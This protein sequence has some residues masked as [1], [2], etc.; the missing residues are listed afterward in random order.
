MSQE[1]EQP[2]VLFDLDDSAAPTTQNHINPYI[3]KLAPG[4]FTDDQRNRP[5]V[6]QQENPELYE[7]RQRFFADHEALV[8]VELYPTSIPALEILKPVCSQQGL[9]SRLSVCAP[10][11]LAW[12]ERVGLDQYLTQI[13]TRE[14]PRQRHEFYKLDKAKTLGAVVC[15]DDDPDVCDFYRAGDIFAVVIAQDWNSEIRNGKFIRRYPNMLVAA[16]EIA[17]F[18][19]IFDFIEYYNKD[20]Q[21]GSYFSFP[22]EPLLQAK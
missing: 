10:S 20:R 1:T 15:F 17:R 8:A 9:T 14:D 22:D 21:G 11:T 2:L 3:E 5:R 6:T 7:L 16:R 12:A 18:P 13:H 4:R 19:T